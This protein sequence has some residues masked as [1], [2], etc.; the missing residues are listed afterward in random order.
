M[1]RGW[2]EQHSLHSCFEEL[3]ES[4]ETA[5][6]VFKS[7]LCLGNPSVKAHKEGNR[8]WKPITPPYKKQWRLDSGEYP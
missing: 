1:T 6:K 7:L 3:T 2:H 5:I 8:G 4:S